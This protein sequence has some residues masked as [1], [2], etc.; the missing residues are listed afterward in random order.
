MPETCRRD[1]WKRSCG[2]PGTEPSRGLRLR[3]RYLKS[4][5]PKLRGIAMAYPFKKRLPVTASMIQIKPE[6]TLR[7]QRFLADNWLTEDSRGPKPFSSSDVYFQYGRNST[8]S[9][10]GWPSANP[11]FSSRFRF[12]M[13]PRGGSFH[14]ESSASPCVPW[15]GSPCMNQLNL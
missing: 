13:T 7:S 12:M 1:R 9:I 2:S 3:L 6:D 10:C 15:D 5:L 8:T 14:V 11:V 4:S